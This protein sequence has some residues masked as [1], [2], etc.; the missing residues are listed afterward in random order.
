MPMRNV[1]NDFPIFQ[2]QPGLVYLDSAATA[3]KPQMVLDKVNEYYTQ[4]SANVHRGLYPLAEKSTEEY[5]EARA[6][7]ARFLNAE[8]NEII[9]TRSATEAINLV[10]HSFGRHLQERL[11]SNPAR[12]A[13]KGRGA[14]IVVT[15]LEHHS[16]IVP[17]HFVTHSTDAQGHSE[18]RRRVTEEKDVKLIW[19][20]IEEDGTLD[21]EVLD[22]IL[23]N[24]KVGLVAVTGMSNVLGALPPI[25]EIVARAHKAG[26]KILVDAAQLAVHRPLD[27]KKLNVD[28][29]AFTGHKLYGPTGIGVLYG[30]IDLL[31]SMPA[32]QGGGEMI[33]EVRKD[34]VTLKD[35]PHKFEAGTPPIAQA[36]G[37][38][39]A[40]EYFQSLGIDEVSR[41]E[42]ELTQYAV[43]KLSEVPGLTILGPKERGPLVAFTVEGIHPHDL[44][45]LLGE[46]NIAIRA[47]HHCTMPLHAALNI[48]ASARASFGVYTRH[49]D[50][51]RLIVGL[52]K[53][54]TKFVR[55]RQKV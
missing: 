49:E 1:R 37:L 51:D 42:N 28:F 8:P 44:A 38:G 20:P 2:A 5:E 10:A 33:R 53:I 21:L 34:C 36:I 9:F 50:I 32:Y 14:A 6:T 18:Q 26:A 7:V 48:P 12:A 4:Y 35:S 47:G 11:P 16:N 54:Q 3:L 46:E 43:E 52:K 19:W 24:E 22:S 13:K 23:E 41:H 39:A 45:T 55:A 15:E 29:L 27:V 30:K 25:A 17:W 40:I 31:E